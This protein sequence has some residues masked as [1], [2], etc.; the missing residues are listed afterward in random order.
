MFVQ[1][2][3]ARKA[4][5]DEEQSSHQAPFPGARSEPVQP[6]DPAEH[7]LRSCQISELNAGTVPLLVLMLGAEAACWRLD[8]IK[9]SLK[10]FSPH[11]HKGS[12]LSNV[13][14]PS[15]RKQLENLGWVSCCLW[16]SYWGSV[17]CQAFGFERRFLVAGANHPL[18]WSRDVSLGTGQTLG[19]R[20]T[21]WN[22]GIY[23]L[24]RLSENLFLH[25]LAAPALSSGGA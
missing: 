20:R 15:L 8:N 24:L 10:P 25:I 22:C 11:R 1:W 23:I 13:C 2:R 17:Y 5:A 19:H 12:A 21:V 3:Y 9:G 6:V 18:S 16:D 7:E 14:Q 4:A